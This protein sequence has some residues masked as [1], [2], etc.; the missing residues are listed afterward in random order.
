MASGSFVVRAK[1]APDIFIHAAGQLGLPVSRCVVLEDAEAG[2]SG[3][4]EGGFRTVGIGPEE[5]VGHAQIRF[6]STKG[7]AEF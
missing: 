2:V 3:A 4:M 1:P 6:D 7:L 5:R